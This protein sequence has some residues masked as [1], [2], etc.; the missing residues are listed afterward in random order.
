MKCGKCGSQWPDKMKFCGECGSPLAGGEARS[1]ARM[2]T[3][4]RRHAVVL[5]A[6]IKGYTSLS[7]EL[8]PEELHDV[9]QLVYNLMGECVSRHGG[10]TAKYIGDCAMA[11]FGV[12][13]AHENDE[14]RAIRC[15]LEMHERIAKHPGIKGKRLA[16]T[17]GIN[18]GIVVAG[19]IGDVEKFD[20]DAL[21]DTVN[22]AARLQGEADA[23]QTFVSERVYG[24]AKSQF[25]W[26]QVGPFELKNV[27]RP[28][29]AFNAV[30]ER[31]PLEASKFAGTGMAALCG[32]ELEIKKIEKALADTAAGE[33]MLFGITGEAGVGKSR[34]VYELQNRAE[35]AGIR[36]LVGLNMPYGSNIPLQP[37]QRMVIQLAAPGG[38][39]APAPDMREAFSA[40]W[41]DS[42]ILETRLAAL[43]R[44]LGYSPEDPVIDRLEGE[45][46]GK[47]LE[48]TLNEL[49]CSIA[50][51]DKSRPLV[52]V[53]EDMQWAS[54]E[55]MNWVTQFSRLIRDRKILMVLA[56]R[57]G[58]EHEFES[59]PMIRF[60]EIRL[61]P[62]AADS[63]GAMVL[64]IL[65]AADAPVELF[66]FVSGKSQ[67]NPFFAEEI[68]RHLLAE[69]IIE[70]EASEGE[71]SGRIVINRPLDKVN[72]PTTVQTLIMSR[73]DRLEFETRRTLQEASVIGQ[74]FLEEILAEI[75]SAREE[76]TRRLDDLISFEIIHRGSR[77]PD[78]EYVFRHILTRDA[79]YDTL[80]KSERRELHGQIA[81]AIEGVFPERLD[82]FYALLA[83]HLESAGELKRA[84]R[85]FYFE[86][87]KLKESGDTKSSL[88][89]MKK[90]AGYID[91]ES[92]E[93]VEN[94]LELADT[95]LEI[96]SAH[97]AENCLVRLPDELADMHLVRKHLV[98]AEISRALSEYEKARESYEKAGE[99]SR[100][101][102][103]GK[104]LSK[105]LSGLG[106]VMIDTGEYGKAEAFLKDAL[107][108]SVE[109]KEASDE[110]NILNSLGLIQSRKSEN[111]KALEYFAKAS[112][113][114]E[115]LGNRSIE[116][117][118]LVNIGSV[119]YSIGEYDRAIEYYRKGLDIF[120]LL[121][122]RMSEAET[123]LN[124]GSVHRAWG[125]FP[126][127]L[128]ALEES[129]R[130]RREIGDRSGEAGCLNNIGLVYRQQ[131]EKKNAM[132]CF[133]QSLE[134]NR[135]IGNR[136]GE[137]VALGNLGITSHE[138]GDM[139]AALDYD[140][141]CLKIFEDIGEPQSQ[142]AILSHIGLVH[143][144]LHEFDMAL[145]C[146]EKCL[147]IQR[148]IRDYRMM[149]YT[150]SNSAALYM[151]MGDIG[152]AAAMLK[153][154]LEVSRSIN[155]KMSEISILWNIGIACFDMGKTEEALD[156]YNAAMKIAKDI[157]AKDSI[158]YVN[159]EIAETHCALG[160]YNEAVRA[161]EAVISYSREK[162]NRAGLCKSL[163][164][165][166][167]LKAEKGEED[168]AREL[169]EE[170][171]DLRSSLGR[172][173]ELRDFHVS[174]AI[175]LAAMRG[176][177]EA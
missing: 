155:E 109:G 40:A 82:R 54:Q 90:A 42:E 176:H 57:P 20:F 105:A 164:A 136:R 130:I 33:G 1:S 172:G 39:E 108:I 37:L 21:G 119:H 89:T 99:E 169:L 35:D 14:A 131:G 48:V 141:K 84:G 140:R 96:E 112:E 142:A 15:A 17:I 19:D 59:D 70:R 44:F 31:D 63:I 9:M 83:H 127:A 133:R 126:S 93:F 24:R 170:A 3:R 61:R 27:R 98:Q 153:E 152:K 46:R 159:M 171:I 163:V 80:L 156:N 47:L 12:P 158:A 107:E 22:V 135:K 95:A 125:D 115:R 132:E 124:I 65:S 168:S 26:E 174:A 161:V 60:S 146:Y 25:D 66:E 128:K 86:G 79:V 97:E 74:S 62:I 134:I 101:L 71:G 23:G 81:A 38:R 50:E 58:L 103:D 28:V 68:V 104:L 138:F 29:A 73:I 51:G 147:R 16:L 123:L 18:A 165:A 111:E 77:L 72:L 167:G 91:R 106:A 64:S 100:I 43:N 120:R 49:F 7:A 151:K 2:R 6:D 113:L 137:G 52:L 41:P 78:I 148:E 116:A 149:A 175:T 139:P 13:K 144:G 110:A 56:Y 75:S 177:S 117:L 10:T 121:G 8:D 162:E 85:Y 150:L 55:M 88:A 173:E 11:L 45:E 102:N 53:F 129:L 154:A 122:N 114:A 87:R 157:G 92:E 67:G 160:N 94:I 166:A 145:E 32:R 69:T 30:K 36:V 4:E 76:L 118:G 143:E 5:F 34:L